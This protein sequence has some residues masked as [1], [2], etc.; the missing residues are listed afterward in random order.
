MKV[1]AFDLFLRQKRFD[2]I[3]KYIYLKNK[4]KNTQFF[5][6]LYA[7]HIRA[8]NGFYEINPS[9][10]IPKNTCEDFIKSFDELYDNM[11][12]RGFDKKHG[13]IPIGDNGEI[14]DG[15]HRLT[16]AAVLGLDVELEED[17]RNDLYDYKFF[18]N[19]GIDPDM[20]D[21]AALEYVKLN[22][23]AYIV[24]LQ[25]I[26]DTKFDS[27]VEQ[28]LE[29]Y[30]FI[31]YKKNVNITFNG[32]VNLKKLSY[33]SFWDR[34]SWIG[35]AENS[36]AGAVYHANNS[37]GKNPMRIYV[38]VCDKLADV[39][40]A[41]SEIRA[42]FNIGNF[43]VHINDT[44]EEAIA[45][46]QTY[47][48]KNSLYMINKRP[49]QY[50][51]NH[52]DNM[53]T[54][55]RDATHNYGIDLNDVCG[56]GSTPLDVFGLRKSDDLDFLY[57][58]NKD[59]NIQTET[60]SNHDTELVYYP[61]SKQ[62]IIFNPMNHLYYQGVKIITLDILFAMK[63]KRHEIPKDVNDCKMIKAF[64]RGKKY[65]KSNFKIFRKIRDGQK[66]TLVFFNIIKIHYTKRGCRHGL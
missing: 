10:G 18:Q 3:F 52:F 12:K 39:L 31:Y 20:A 7:E 53:V 5:E 43:C 6:N 24:N 55:L 37:F 46:A 65:R 11:S 44:R 56:G 66:R 25:S 45:L 50:E 47:F 34:E 28:I 2:L 62:E 61:Y 40:A 15:A 29:K 36:F 8:F 14:S 49:Y 32:L 22:P 57:C 59:F 35:T 23:N 38:F 19:Q 21:Y 48:N 13:I 58:G 30:G 26:I 33:G 63:Q 51:D 16:C 64:K 27:Q 9:D 42:L 41:K 17:H 54:E 60:L 4:D 1:N